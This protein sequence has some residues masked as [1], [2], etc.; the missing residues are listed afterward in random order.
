MTQLNTVGAKYVTNPL[1]RS[2]LLQQAAGAI[3]GAIPNVEKIVGTGF[4]LKDVS[5]DGAHL[6]LK[7]YGLDG[8]Y[9]MVKT[10]NGMPTTTSE[11]RK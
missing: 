11:I 6:T 7:K 4:G 10:M 2:V 5:T 3:S 8:F 9:G 1:I